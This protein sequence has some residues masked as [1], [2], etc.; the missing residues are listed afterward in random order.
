MSVAF[1]SAAVGA[2]A[3]AAALR[4]ARGAERL[5]WSACRRLLALG[6]WGVLGSM[7]TWCQTQSYVYLLLAM[8]G[9]TA[10]AAASA[11]RIV[12]APL[13]LVTSGWGAVYKPWGARISGADSER[14]RGPMVDATTRLTLLSVMYGIVAVAAHAPLVEHVLGDRYRGIGRADLALWAV[15]FAILA[16][17]GGL[18]NTLQVLQQFRALFFC[19]LGGAVVAVLA[20][21]AL[22]TFHGVLGSLVGLIAG[23]IVLTLAALRCLTLAWRKPGWIR[24]LFVETARR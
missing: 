14:L 13:A 22:I 18:T 4:S 21:A 19:S 20:G 12:F 15:Y 6:Q 24:W 23:E 10:T 9:A 7:V 2:L 5:S 17:R 8:V 3:L 11:S 16:I 1:A